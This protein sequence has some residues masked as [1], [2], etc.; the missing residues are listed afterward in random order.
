LL[1]DALNQAADDGEHDGADKRKSAM[2]KQ[3]PFKISQNKPSVRIVIGRVINC[4]NGFTKLLTSP[5]ASAATKAPPNPETWIPGK[6]Q[7]KI[8]TLKA[9]IS[10][11]AKRAAILPP[12]P[13]W[14]S[15]FALYAIQL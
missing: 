13:R 1:E 4:R 2:A 8:I 12:L 11:V 5:M 15:H 9:D 6:S 10:Q 3:M 14:G 7:A